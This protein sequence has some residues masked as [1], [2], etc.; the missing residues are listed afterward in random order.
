MSH[1]GL[2][3]LLDFSF[4]ELGKDLTATVGIETIGQFF[5]QAEGFCGYI[6]SEKNET[7]CF[8]TLYYLRVYIPMYVYFLST[9]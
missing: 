5:K 7:R 9:M 1:W 6:I 2:F 4:A 3:F 8:Q